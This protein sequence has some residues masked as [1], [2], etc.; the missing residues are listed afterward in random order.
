MN[1][2]ALIKNISIIIVDSFKACPQGPAPLCLN[3]CYSCTFVFHPNSSVAT[4]LASR[5]VAT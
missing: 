2:S 1:W 3:I 5:S 4:L